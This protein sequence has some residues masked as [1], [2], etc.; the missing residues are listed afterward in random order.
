DG[1]SGG[2]EAVDLSKYPDLNY[3]LDDC[4]LVVTLRVAD[5]LNDPKIKSAFQDAVG[6]AMLAQAEAQMGMKVTDVER[7]TIVMTDL[8][9]EEGYPRVARSKP[10]DQEKLK[11]AMGDQS[12]GKLGETTYKGKTLYSEPGKPG[13]AACFVSDRLMIAGKTDGVKKALDNPA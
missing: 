6:G 1:K 4:Q 8:N 13:E 2:G 3:V 5:A 12:G 10:Y 11:K 7:V 9:Q